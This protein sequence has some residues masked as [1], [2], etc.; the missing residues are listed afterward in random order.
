MYLTPNKPKKL[1]NDNKQKQLKKSNPFPKMT[2]HDFHYISNSLNTVDISKVS[3]LQELF[4]QSIEKSSTNMS[5]LQQTELRR[6]MV[7]EKLNISPSLFDSYSTN[8]QVE[9]IEYFVN[10]FMPILSEKVPSGSQ[11]F[12]PKENY[13]QK[14]A[15]LNGLMTGLMSF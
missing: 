3:H 4:K 5:N 13:Q 12:V 7:S 2:R 14:S 15:N 11:N 1:Y 9:T 10:N 8:S 6:D